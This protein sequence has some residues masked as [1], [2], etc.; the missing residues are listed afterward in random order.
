MKNRTQI[1]IDEL[2]AIQASKILSIEILGSRE[3]ENDLAISDIDFLII[4]KS[5]RDIASVFKTALEVQ[6]KIFEIKTTRTNKIIQKLF[7]GSNSYSGVHLVVLGRDELDDNFRPI[8]LRL[9]FMTKLVGK[10][11]FLYE[12]QQNHHLLYGKNLADEIRIEQPNF[13]EK[14]TCFIFPSIVLIF[15][16]PTLL[17]SRHTFKIWCF[18]A[19]KYHNIS[20]RAFIKITKQ[21]YIFDNTLFE[22]AKFFRYKP[23]E[24]LGNP[25]VLY[26]RVWGHIFGNVPFLFFKKQNNLENIYERN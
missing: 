22:T 17:F 7:L 16:L 11:L 21:N 1:F 6:E 14:L 15:S 19:V 24:Y 3:G 13:S 26:I 10:N 9:R 25:L 4:C 18:K 20:L 12:I 2:V 8:S 23:A 5:K